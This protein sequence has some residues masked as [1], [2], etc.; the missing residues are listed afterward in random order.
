M[1]VEIS[2]LT[3]LMAQPNDENR[4]IDFFVRGFAVGRRIQLWE[5]ISAL[6]RQGEITWDFPAARVGDLPVLSDDNR[7]GARRR[8]IRP[9]AER[10]RL[11]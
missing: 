1:A 9:A 8:R 4:K 6:V 5:S 10:H 7:S 2:S 11:P 3:E